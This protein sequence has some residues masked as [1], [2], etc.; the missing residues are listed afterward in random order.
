MINQEEYERRHRKFVIE[1][2]QLRARNPVADF[3]TAMILVSAL[4]T[5]V[6]RILGL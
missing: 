6:A 4:G 2:A 3:V 5:L 1:T